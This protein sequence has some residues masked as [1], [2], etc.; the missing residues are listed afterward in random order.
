[1]DVN[2]K[3]GSLELYL[4]QDVLK[5]AEGELI[6]VRWG[7]YEEKIGDYQGAILHKG[8]VLKEFDKKLASCEAHPERIDE[9]DWKGMRA[10]LNVMFTAFHP[11]DAQSILMGI[12]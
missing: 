5:D 8:R 7:A 9:H 12:A 10:I 4:G 1:M 6:P 2:G 11:V 3:A